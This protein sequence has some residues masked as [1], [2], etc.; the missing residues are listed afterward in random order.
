M[1]TVKLLKHYISSSLAVKMSAVSAISLLTAVVLI[2][3]VGVA[4]VREQAEAAFASSSRVKLSQADDALNNTFRDFSENLTYLAGT[5]DVQAADQSLT[6]YLSNGEMTEHGH[7]EIETLMFKLFRRFGE[8]HRNMRYL[9]LGTKWGGYVQWPIESFSSGHYDPRVRPWYELATASPDH[10]VRPAPYLNASGG[11]GIGLSFS[12]SV[13]NSQGEIIGVIESDLTLEAFTSSIKSLRF[14]DTGYVIVVDEN[15][16]VVTNP[17]NESHALKTLMSLGDGYKSLASS[18]DGLTEAVM[19][20]AHYRAFVYTSPKTSWKYYALVPSS[21]MTAAAD[22]LTLTLIGISVVVTV[23]ALGITLT[24]GRRVTSPLRNL[25][26]SMQEIA[27]GDGDMTRRLPISG[28]DEVGHLATQFNA[29][30]EKLHGVLVKTLESSR[31]IEV[32]ASEVSIGN[33][34]LSARTE[35]QAASIQESAATMEQIAGTVQQ[36]ARQSSDVTSVVSDAAQIARDGNE[37]VLKAATTM[38]AAADQSAKIEGIVAMIEGIAFQTN[39]L[40]LNAGVEAARAGDSGRG[41][42]VVASEVRDLAQRSLGAS[43][44]IK[45]LLEASVHNVR[46]G[47][48]QVNLAGR[49]IA[50]LKDAIANVAKI[51]EE[52][53][54]STHE[55]SHAIQE[56]N[57]AVASMDESTQQNAAL[58]EQISA[59]S[60]SLKNQSIELHSTIGFFKLH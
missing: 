55:Q 44:E 58:V 32:A 15:G 17:R 30:V 1:Q 36:T 56:I 45:V 51:T 48:G 50:E 33:G 57:Q 21:E 52:I 12:R 14:G 47:A 60:E 22:R 42:A 13:R 41:F 16:N 5:A 10:V 20:G 37:A 18:P 11:G 9:G 59:A 34:D 28:S 35:Q 8:A 24:L 54:A 6:N 3:S 31:E 4:N 38:N 49:T 2:T 25:A 40:A 53:S 39:I 43:K 23:A 7:G 46:A 26:D 29:F 19:D 27:S